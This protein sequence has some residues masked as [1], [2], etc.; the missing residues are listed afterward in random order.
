MQDRPPGPALATL[1]ALRPAQ[2]YGRLSARKLWHEG[3]PG[4]RWLIFGAW[5]LSLLLCIATGLATVRYGW[6]GLPLEFGGVQ[7]HVTVYPPLLICMWWTLSLGWWWGA[8]PAYLATLL[9]ALDGGMAPGW[10][11]VFACANPLGFAVLVLGYRAIGISRGLRSLG[12]LL[13]YVQLS[14]VASVFGSAGALIWS[15]SQGLQ[16]QALLAI[17]QGWWLGS[18]LQS[19]LLVGPLMYLS[20]PLVEAWLWRHPELQRA[21]PPGSRRLGLGLLASIVVA[22]LAYG[23]LTIWLGGQQLDAALQQTQLEP[24]RQAALTLRATTWAFYWV[25]ALIV[26]FLGWFIYQS[27]SRWLLSSERMILQLAQVNAELERRS[28]TDGLSGL[29]NRMATE[30]LLRQLHRRARR[31]GESMA[32]LMLDIDHFKNIND[33]HGHAAGDAVIRALAQVLRAAV[34][35]VDVAGRYGGEEFVVALSNSEAAGACAFAERLRA[36][37]ARQ[38]VADAGGPIPYS[39]SIGIAMLAPGDQEIESWLKR[40]DTA[41]YQAKQGGRD[42]AVLAAI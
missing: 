18:F 35:E 29:N 15:Y 13:F 34:R 22:V 31:Y 2:T 40:A 8:V 10:A 26:L 19:V 27:F 36:Q 5:G 20:W 17:W 32:V 12:S 1:D 38:P 6:S 21:A 37:I 30:D 16:S 7:I 33:R 39:V 23:L 9:L 14:F 24:L 41:L 42:R 28:R 11:L 4:Q 3:S 25:F